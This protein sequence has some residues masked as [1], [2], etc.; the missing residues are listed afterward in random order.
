M[1]VEHRLAVVA[2]CPV[3]KLPDIYQ[4]SV[5]TTRTIKVE[6][7]LKAVGELT[8]KSLFQEEFTQRLHRLLACE[9]ETTGWHSGVLTRV[10]CGAE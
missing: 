7:I 10:V 3:D 5:R 6:D 9:V 2:T 4:C 8:K 1:R